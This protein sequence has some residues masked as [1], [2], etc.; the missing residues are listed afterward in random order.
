MSSYANRFRQPKNRKNSG[1]IFECGE[2]AVTLPTAAFSSCGFGSLKRESGE[3]TTD[4]LRIVFDDLGTL[5]WT[6][7]LSTN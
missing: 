2:M 7:H 6:G 3:T 1:T 5:V 4:F